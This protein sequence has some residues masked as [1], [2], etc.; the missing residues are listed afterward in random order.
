MFGIIHGARNII[1]EIQPVNVL[2]NIIDKINTLEKDRKLVDSD[3]QIHL[4]KLPNGITPGYLET[5]VYAD[6]NTCNVG[7]NNGLYAIGGIPIGICIPLAFD[8]AFMLSYT[9]AQ[10]DVAGVGMMDIYEFTVYLYTANCYLLLTSYPL[11]T[12]DMFY[13]PAQC[14]NYNDYS[15]FTNN[16]IDGYNTT[17]ISVNLTI[18]SS[19]T[20]YE[21]PWT[22]LTNGQYTFIYTTISACDN[23]AVNPSPSVR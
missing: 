18:V 15:K 16:T 2:S 13:L 3:N 12:Q 19:F 1:S 7:S 21:T 11:P 17:D 6:T 10:T 14:V 9:T 23:A 20:T 5:K 4:R 8:T 22:T